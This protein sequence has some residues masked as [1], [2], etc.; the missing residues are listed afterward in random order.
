[1]I[2][3]A[4]LSTHNLS[5]SQD[6]SA[7][8][9]LIR[10]GCEFLFF[11][12]HATLFIISTYLLLSKG[13][14]L[15]RARILLLS[16]TTIMFLASL[17]VIIIDMM[18]CLQQIQGY[19]PG[20]FNN[21]TLS[22]KLIMASNVLMRVNFLLGDVIVV[23]RTWVVWPHNIMFRLL[24][25]ACMLGTI[26]AIIGN[27]AKS[28]L[29]SVRGTEASN[30]YSLVMT[31]PP[32]ITNLTATLLIAFQSLGIQKRNQ[33]QMS[34][35]KSTTRIEK[36]LILLVESGFI[37]CAVWLLILVAGFDVMK[38]SH[39]NSNIR[40]CSPAWTGLY[41]TFIVIMVSV[42]KIPRKHHL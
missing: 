2:V 22:S 13:I 25:A 20:P 24:L 17:G 10:I 9:D 40:C 26:G 36:T 11:G 4:T 15:V 31:L 38:P 39:H 35:A 19:G 41:P 1:M 37:Y 5:A 7:Q 12:I 28:A 30:V 29:D 32:L 18:I 6:L 8:H 33:I 27:G 42:D 16:L 23:W 3:T 21:L 14:R 34:S